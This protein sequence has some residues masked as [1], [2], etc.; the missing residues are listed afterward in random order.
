MPA[1]SDSELVRRAQKNDEEAFRAL[2]E[3]YIS[4]TGSIAYGLLGDFSLAEDAVQETFL[5]VYRY[6]KSL[7]NPAMFRQFLARTAKTVALGYIRKEKAEKRG[8][9]LPF[10]TFQEDKE[11]GVEFSADDDSSPETTLTDEELSRLVLREIEALPGD[12]REV[13]VMRY[14]EGLGCEEMAELLDE[15]S[16]AVE[17]RLFRAREILRQKLKRYLKGD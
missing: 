17:A 11:E 7:K 13:I 3:R 6:L 12:Y 15:N 2:V 16:T 5:R 14:L 10:S 1:E 9:P 4:L 8:H